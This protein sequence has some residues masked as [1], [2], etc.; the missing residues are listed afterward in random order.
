MVLKN[1]FITLAKKTKMAQNTGILSKMET[2]KKSP[3]IYYLILENQKIELNQLIGSKIRMEFLQEI[4]CLKC[5]TKT[6]KSYAQG[7]CYPCFISIPETD[8]CILHPEK[9]EAQNGISRD[10][11]WSKNHC[12][13]DHYVYLAVSS[14]LKVGVTRSTQVPTRWIDQGALK[15]IKL[16]KTPNRNLAGLIEVSLKKHLADKTNWRNM[17]TNKVEDVNLVESKEKVKTIFDEQFLPYIDKD[18]NV[19][20]FEYPVLQYPE[21]VKSINLDK[22]PV[23]EKK[24]LG[25]KGQYFL[26]EDNFVINIRKYGGYKVLFEY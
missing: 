26:F 13:Q 4:R 20:S 25:I 2:E 22:E 23:I 9:C 17:L 7:Y 1:I 16:A 15:A 10:M 12:L 14:G 21:K 18:N 8:E 24:L 19:H 11:E 5:G 3:I 6:K